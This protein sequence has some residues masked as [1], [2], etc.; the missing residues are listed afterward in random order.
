[1][2]KLLLAEDHHLVRGAFVALLGAEP[3]IE[4]VAE[5]G[6]GDEAVRLAVELRPDVAMLDIDMPGLDGLTAA[7]RIHQDAPGCQ[8]VIVTGHGRPGYLRRAMA[9]G[10]R[11]FVGK[12]NPAA[13][14]AKV[15]RQVHEGGRYIDPELAADALSMRE[16][17]LTPR[18][19]DTLRAASSGAPVSRIA[20]ELSLSEGTVRNY[21]SSAVTK[22]AVEN[23]HT[24]V[25]RARD[26]GWL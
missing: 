16:C 1:M 26:M 15:I 21:L 18:E 11:G 4:V 6:R 24:A 13:A 17:P 10:V 14:L 3:D 20:R 7:E 5:T 23:R 25:R 9:A 8:V 19:L 22:L 2:I 12:D